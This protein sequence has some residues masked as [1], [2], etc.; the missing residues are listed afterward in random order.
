MWPLPAIADVDALPAE[1]DD[2][3]RVAPAPEAAKPGPVVLLRA[4]RPR[5]WLK[6]GVVVIAPAAAGV[7]AKPRLVPAICGAFVA[8][9]LMS[10]ATYLIND[11]KD[12]DADRRHPRKRLRPIAAGELSLPVARRA[13]CALALAAV[14]VAA[15]VRPALVLAVLGYAALTLSYTL[16]WRNIV[17]ADIL[18]VAGGFV[19]RALGGGAAVDVSLSRSFLVVTSACALFLIVGKRHAEAARRHAAATRST[20]RRYSRRTLW[21]LLASS[22][23]IGCVAYARWS[24]G[25]PELGPWLELSQIPFALWLCRYALSVRRG[26]GEAPEELILQDPGLLA[27]GLLWALLFTAGIYGGP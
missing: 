9:C 3:L 27:L 26:G 25:R 8:F 10:S 24:L 19:L 12:R 17:I 2:R 1:E 15:L 18:A 11:V 14:I 16:W 5:Q 7:L 6:N 23:T 22:G 4:C 13:A 21:L 20:L